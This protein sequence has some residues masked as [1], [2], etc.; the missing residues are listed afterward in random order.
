MSVPRAIKRLLPN[1]AKSFVKNTGVLAYY[2]KNSRQVKAMARLSMLGEENQQ[3]Y[4]ITRC[5]ICDSGDYEPLLRI[6]FGYPGGQNHSLFYYDYRNTDIDQVLPLKDKLD[7]TFGFVLSVPWG[8]CNRCQKGSLALT[9]A[10]EQEHLDVFYSRYY[11]R[12][13]PM[14]HNRRATK[15][16]HGDYLC[17]FL[18]PESTVLEIGS[19]EGF[20]ANYVAA[21][22]HRVLVLEQS[23]NYREQLAGSPLIT[24]ISSLE[25][26]EDDSLDALYMHQVFE[27][28]ASPMEFARTLRPLLKKGGVLFLQSPDLSLEIN[29]WWEKFLLRSVYSVLNRP[30]VFKPGIEYDFWSAKDYYPWFGAILDTHVTGFTPEGFR[31]VIENAGFQVEQVLQSTADRVV[32]DPEKYAWP[33]DGTTG[34]IPNSLTLVAR[35]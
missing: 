26:I 23:E 18:S 5:P 9:P 15:E 34:D 30:V 19:A 33:V 8:F 35:K 14:H 2:L 13:V 27:H 12:A 20:T 4:A 7:R 6:P 21:Q 32:W 10:T 22:G 31:Y 29:P 3:K 25:A 1:R 28:V 17:T 16:L 11:D 24:P